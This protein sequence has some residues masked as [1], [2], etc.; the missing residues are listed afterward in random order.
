MIFEDLLKILIK[1]FNLKIGESIDKEKFKNIYCRAKQIFE[2]NNKKDF[3]SPKEFA[4]EYLQLT[5]SSYKALKG[6]YQKAKILKNYEL[7]S[8]EIL[9]IRRKIIYKHKLHKGELKTYEELKEIFETNSTVFQ[10]KEFFEKILD[11]KPEKLRPLIREYNKAVNKNNNE[12]KKNKKPRTEILENEII[13]KDEIK[14]IRDICLKEKLLH[15]KDRI[16][17]KRF[18]ELYDEYFIPLSEE[19]FAKE[20]L[21]INL[22]T[23]KNL[24][25]YPD[26]TRYILMEVRLPENI[27]EIREKIVQ[28]EKLHIGD[29]I[30]Y[31]EFS[32]ILDNNYLPISRQDFAEKILDIDKTNLNS[33][34]YDENRHMTILKKEVVSKERIISLREEVIRGLRLHKKDKITYK[35]LQEIYTKYYI[36]LSE[37]DFAREILDIDKDI[38]LAIKY[39]TRKDTTIL[40]NLKIDEEI[41][42]ETKNKILKEFYIGKKISYKDFK[43]IYNK[44]FVPLPENEY[45]EKI[46][47]FSRSKLKDIKNPKTKKSENRK[48]YLKTMIFLGDK[49][50]NL[51]EEII[52]KNNLYSNQEIT[53]EFFMKLY[54]SEKHS[55]SYLMFGKLMFGLD[56]QETNALILGRNRKVIIKTNLSEDENKTNKNEFL[57]AQEN[58]I[59]HLLYE[60]KTNSEIIDEL[61]LSKYDDIDTIIER[62]ILNQGL[63]ENI[64]KKNRVR[65][66]IWSGIGLYKTSIKLKMSVDEVKSILKDIILEEIEDYLEIGY[67]LNDTIKI[68]KIK[69][70]RKSQAKDYTS[71]EMKLILK[72][73]KRKEILR[74]KINKLLD[75][76]KILNPEYQDDLREYINIC[77]KD[78]GEDNFNLLDI[79]LLENV[80]LSIEAEDDDI[81]FFVKLCIKNQEYKRANGFVSYYIEDM[82]RST[83]E[84]KK[85]G[86]LYKI[87]KE[88]KIK[89][90]NVNDKYSKEEGKK[91]KRTKIVI[92]DFKAKRKKAVDEILKEV[93]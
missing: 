65:N 2:E 10:E 63:N 32:K 89:S 77:K 71:K 40:K 15:R 73:E 42:A 92:E 9:E 8:E 56:L 62:T 88:A 93:L 76:G 6:G 74:N 5:K 69:L 31:K 91:S 30:T 33:A 83:E 36:P 12:D 39:G 20:M 82:S 53:R 38:Y 64:I 55:L 51:R 52:R 45:C 35:Q 49:L 61:M 18:L 44:Y 68:I 90:D 72:Q 23:Y 57:K 84:R 4:L 11:I 47:E 81:Q 37:E 17:Y 66:K 87:I 19:D 54:K 7:T 50:E 3:L 21:D 85:L 1:E 70:K 41:I 24:K 26:K 29:S 28:K 16:N 46:L 58:Y 75:N 13:D 79:D 86:M 60:G 25:F 22:K 80:I 27:E 59:A 67:S 43:Y 78:F 48:V 34:K 14:K